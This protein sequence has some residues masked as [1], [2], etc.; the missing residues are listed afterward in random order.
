[1]PSRSRRLAL[2]REALSALSTY[3]MEA[4]AAGASPTWQ[5]SCMNDCLTLDRCPTVPVRECKIYVVSLP[6]TSIL[7]GTA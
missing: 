7:E 3:E 1:M 6:D 2:R 5:P 4:V